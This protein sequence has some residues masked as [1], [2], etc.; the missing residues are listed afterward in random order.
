MQRR[1]L[2]RQGVWRNGGEWENLF[3]LGAQQKERG[4]AIQ[5]C[6][7]EAKR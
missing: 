6:Q 1:A 7:R 4:C 5:L 3:A 2:F